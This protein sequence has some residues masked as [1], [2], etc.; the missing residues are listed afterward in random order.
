LSA[1]F[2]FRARLIAVMSLAK[3]VQP[4]FWLSKPLG[5][6]PLTM[7]KEQFVVSKLS[8]LYTICGTLC[9]LVGGLKKF[10]RLFFRLTKDALSGQDILSAA[11]NV[12]V[13][14]FAVL[15]IYYSIVCSR[16]I[17]GMLNNLGQLLKTVKDPDT[18]TVAKQIRIMVFVLQI[19]VFLS[20]MAFT[21]YE[22]S[23]KSNFIQIQKLPPLTIFNCKYV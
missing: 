16:R 8:Q 13:M 3:I 9:F 20:Y 6:L 19:A 17:V 14:I 1:L 18:L 5:V 10:V 4:L 12:I 11:S 2:A 23:F 22:S 7:E 21:I 15:N